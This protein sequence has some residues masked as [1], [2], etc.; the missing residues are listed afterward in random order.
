MLTWIGCA[1]AVICLAYYVII[2][3]YAGFTVSF[4]G[5]WLVMAILLG[6][7]SWGSRYGRIHP[8]KLPLWAPVS[9]VTFAAAA[10]VIFCV[11]EILIFL[12]AAS[13]DA[14]GLDYVVVLGAKVQ[15]QGISNSLRKRLNKA[16]QYSRENPGT[17][18]ILS[19][20][21]GKDEPMPESQAMYDYLVYN[22][23]PKNRLVME[24]ISVSTVENLA[25]SKV[26]ID[27]LEQEKQETSGN[28]KVPMIPGPFLEVEEKPVEIGVLTSSYHVFRASK[29]AE[30]WGYGHVHGI[31]AKS[32]MVLFPHL[33]VRECVAVLKDR[34][35]GNM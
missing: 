2:V 32:D 23:V 30:K 15:Q 35:M 33:C 24:S 20:G 16:I 11:V 8:G 19:G 26:I 27:R 34:L 3:V 21:Q 1:G 29:I 5:F 4:S 9:A 28:K 12:G 22:G 7:V 14:P 13:A 17:V 10:L 6:A 31:S 25:Y 18:F